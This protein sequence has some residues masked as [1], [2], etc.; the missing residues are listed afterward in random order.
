MWKRSAPRFSSGRESRAGSV[1]T[2]RAVRA[3]PTGPRPAHSVDMLLDGLAERFTRPCGEAFPTLAKGLHAFVRAEE[4]PG[5][6]LHWLWTACP[7]TPEPLAPELWDDQTWHELADRAVSLARAA[8]ALA[9]L[10]TALSYRACVHV[11]AGEFAAAAALISEAD[12]IN[13]A[14]GNAPLSYT[15]LVLLAWRGEEAVGLPAI[16]SARQNAT[17]KGQGRAIG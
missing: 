7:V 16:E 12:A 11:H 5:E 4:G 9:V 13:E 8:G 3:M 6:Q 15:S 14:T 17:A 2:A 1:E 10:P